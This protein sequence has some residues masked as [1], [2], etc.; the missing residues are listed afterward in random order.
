MPCD[1]ATMV[2]VG[3]AEPADRFFTTNA[4]ETCQVVD[5]GSIVVILRKVVGLVMCALCPETSRLHPAAEPAI[6]HTEPSLVQCANGPCGR[7]WQGGTATDKRQRVN[8][9]RHP[10]CY[11]RAVPGDS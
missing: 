8:I 5:D 2:P 11:F 1:R 3:H 6:A 7:Q 9:N 10:H 4:A